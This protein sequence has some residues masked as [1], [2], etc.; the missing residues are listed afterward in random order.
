MSGRVLQVVTDTDRRGA[1]MFA[2]DLEE[3]LRARGADVRTLA[4]TAG[5]NGRT[6]EIPAVGPRRLG[7]TTLS[8]LRTAMDHADV[9]I[10]HG[11]STLPACAI[12][13]AGRG[14][15]FVYRSIGDPLYWAHTSA[16]RA[17]VRLML[18][19][20]A[21][22]A[23]L[24]PGSQRALVER[25]GVEEGKVAVIPNGVPAGRCPPADGAARASARE[26]LGL[27]R[28]AAT[29]A[30]VGAL[31]EEK[32]VQAAVRATGRLAD[33]RLVVV[34][35]GPLRAELE[36][37]AR[38]HA[39]GRVVFTGAGDPRAAFAAADVVCLPSLS[40]GMPGVLIE[41]GLSGLPAVA[42]A[43]GGV[44][45]IVRD[46]ATGRLVPPGS[47]DALVPAL[48]ET[49]A[50]AGRL[51]AE[52]RR[53]CLSRF[54]ITVVAAAWQRLLERVRARPAA[55]REAERQRPAPRP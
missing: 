26:A 36:A 43:V 37:L 7:A 2:V 45:E 34:G 32:D 14:V 11:S 9:V 25:L 24:W 13:G 23:A 53:W 28:E 33:C 3:A 10:A 47:V 18:S 6:L 20:S 30:Y 54:E 1:Q 49:L 44:S 16:R 55:G 46:G 8:R 12:A 31:A 27:P 4:L 19:R 39:P 48:A 51:G 41:A 40:E 22:V 15:P 5:R 17:R 38:R 42:T 52:A 21:A 50:D 35:D 29:I